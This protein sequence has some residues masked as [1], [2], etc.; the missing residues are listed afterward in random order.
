MSFKD[1]LERINIGFFGK[2][3]VRRDRAFIFSDVMFANLGDEVSAGPVRLGF[4]PATLTRTAPVGPRGR[5]AAA[6]TVDIPRVST[7][8]GPAEVDI[9]FKMLTVDLAAGYRVF[10]AP[11][12]QLLGEPNPDDP[13]RFDVD[14]FAGGRYW[15]L[16]PEFTLKV[17]AVTV[18]AVSVNPR[19]ALTGPR[20]RFTREVDFGD[21]EVF[22]GV[23]T[24]GIDQDF[25]ASEWW[26]DPMLGIRL[27]ADATERIKLVVMG[28]V[29]GF[30]IGSAADFSWQAA[31]LLSWQFAEQWSVVTGY[32][33][34][35]VDRDHGDLGLDLVIQG[36]VFG[37]IWRFQL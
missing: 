13:R 32:R 24:A 2:F 16:E 20:G 3:Q 31:G 30:G 25:E 28:D 34:R 11:I 8:V 15:R 36:P 9:E 33:A 5:G 6:A 10:S 29:G 27:G 17:P 37:F 7:L 23:T 19:L 4:G 22:S 12:S 26:I 1:I 21:V 18:P 14:L 35:G